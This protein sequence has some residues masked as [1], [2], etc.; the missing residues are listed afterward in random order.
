MIYKLLL[1]VNPSDFNHFASGVKSLKEILRY[2]LELILHSGAR[3]R[4]NVTLS[5]FRYLFIDVIIS[6]YLLLHIRLRRYKEASC[7]IN[8]LIDSPA[9][10]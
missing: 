10:L 1:S 7:V 8:Y 3:I 5:H 4:L 2:R 6:Q 9:G